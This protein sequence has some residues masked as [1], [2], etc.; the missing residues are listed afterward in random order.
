[1][2][3][4]KMLCFPVDK[5]GGTP[6]RRQERKGGANNG[7]SARRDRDAWSGCR[8]EDDRSWRSTQHTE[9][10]L[11]NPPYRP[12][13]RTGY[14]VTGTRSVADNCGPEAAENHVDAVEKQLGLKLVE[15]KRLVPVLV[16]DHVESSHRELAD[17]FSRPLPFSCSHP[18]AARPAARRTRRG[19]V[20]QGT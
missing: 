20:R 2:R 7:I 3:P 14:A 6:D 5:A 10:A 18:W 16:I 12:G 15:Q 11:V 17:S 1:M 4:P 13:L 8:V 19:Y 9:I